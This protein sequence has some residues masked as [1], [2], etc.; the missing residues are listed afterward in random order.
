MARIERM[1]SEHARAHIL[2]VDDEPAA[3]SALAELLREEGYAVHTAADAFKALGHLEHHHV[4][5]MVT[6]IQMPGMGG[7]E[8]MT[9]V[10]ERLPDVGV[11]VMTAFGSVENAVE[12]MHAGAN[13]YLTKPLHL[14]ELL[15]VLERQLE[16]QRLHHENQRLREALT[17]G[18]GDT[19]GWVG[20]AR[21]GQQ[22]MALARQ[23]APSDVPVLV[24]GGR[25]TGKKLVARAVHRWS[26]RSGGPFV[27]VP[28]A[29]MDD[30]MLERELFGY[31]D[32]PGGFD[33]ARG[34]TLCLEDV[35]RVPLSVQARL[36]AAM[37]SSVGE[38]RVVATTTDELHPEASA[39]RMRDDLFYR[40]SVVTLQVPGLRER[41]DDIP[42][43]AMHFL[44]RHGAEKRKYVRGFSDRALGVLM[45]FDW[46][47]NVRQLAAAVEHAVVMCRGHEIEPRDLPRDLMQP[48][49]ERGGKRAPPI[50]GATLAT[51]ERHAILA[52]LEHVGGSTRRAAQILGISTRKVQYRLNEYREHDPSGVPAVVVAEDTPAHSAGDGAGA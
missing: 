47:G 39:G 40:L 10:R 26:E 3:R 19:M 38:V 17:R 48:Q 52:T 16:H 45:S 12:A 49:H 6:D 51:I 28:C 5:V 4:D 44:E 21:P 33:A 11:L 15:L 25:G 14:P 36:M 41:S 9:K 30:S 20:S 32:A 2:I 43:L 35:G 13:D 22:L 37:R 1:A 31:E 27:V 23:V 42:L 50:P 7:L 29:A 18:I 46:P 34:G 8:L 24:Q